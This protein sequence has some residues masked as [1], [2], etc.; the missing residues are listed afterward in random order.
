MSEEPKERVTIDVRYPN[1]TWTE[2]A[3]RSAVGQKS[4]V[5]DRQIEGVDLHLGEATVI[6]AKVIDDGAAIRLTLE[7]PAGTWPGGSTFDFRDVIGK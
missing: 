7:A 6:A 5:I 1:T 2:E 3:A 4:S